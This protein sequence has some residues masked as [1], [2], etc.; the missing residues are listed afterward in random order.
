MVLRGD[1]G[2]EF[3]EE[4]VGL[5]ASIASPAEAM[6]RSNEIPSSGVVALTN[7]VR[8]PSLVTETASKPR[9]TADRRSAISAA[10][11]DGNYGRRKFS[12]RV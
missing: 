9:A 10:E 6:T 1:V 4:G 3:R 8:E 12:C 11:T 2:R 7:R 5:K